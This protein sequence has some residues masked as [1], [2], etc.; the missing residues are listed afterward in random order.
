MKNVAVI[1]A[2]LG[3]LSAAA[4]LSKKGFNV[5]VFEKNNQVGGRASVF[6]EKG[7]LFDKGPSW[8]LMPEVFEKF[9]AE[10][11]KKPSDFFEL[12]K[13]DPEY[14]IFFEGKKTVDIPAEKNEIKKVFDEFE[15]NGGKKLELY[16]KQAE[17]KYNVALKDFLYRDFNS[18]TDFFNPKL[19]FEGL[20]LHL[21]ESIDKY[22][23]RFFSSDEAK[24]VLEYTMVFLGGSPK[25]T[26]ALYSIM[27]HVDLTLGV[28]YPLG[29]LYELSKSFEEICLTQ[30]IK[31]NL[32]EA[33]EKIIVKNNK[34]TS[35]KTN[36][37][38]FDFDLIIANADYHYV[39][40]VLLEK[41]FQSFNEQYWDSRIMAPSALLFFVGLNKKLSNLQHHNLFLADE[42]NTH[43]NE[44]FE[45]KVWPSNPSYYVC[46]PSKTDSSVAPEGKENLFFLVPV[47]AALNDSNEVREKYF[48]QIITDFEKRIN[49]KIIDS[50]EVKKIY[51]HKDFISDYHSFKGTA[52]GLAHTL[53][54]TAVFRLPRKSKK[55][56]NLFFTGNYNHP[57]IGVPMVIISSHILAEEVL[58]WIK[59]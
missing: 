50:I 13:L 59:N 49:E 14:R 32:N 45:K 27:S 20:K 11:N 5:T 54:Q 1:G 57:G 7:F 24:K 8:Y 29:G 22:V 2:G 40:T 43:F 47:S 12:K 30:G 21:F 10:F 37:G 9:F 6:K 42:W 53:F 56:K 31:I 48:N 4:L 28:W 51:S 52:L 25:N 33:V 38:V 34:A 58:K 35:I 15:E 23:S 19:A 44:I 18:I 26:P 46:C 36:K 3:G 55:V 41:E 39:E 17:Y 16:L